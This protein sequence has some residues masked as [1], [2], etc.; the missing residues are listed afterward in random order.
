MKEMASAQRKRARGWAD[1]ARVDFRVCVF[2]RSVLSA[3]NQST[4]TVTRSLVS[5]RSP[6][7]WPMNTHQRTETRPRFVV[8]F[9]KLPSSREWKS[10]GALCAELLNCRHF[11]GSYLSTALSTHCS[12]LFFSVL[13]YTLGAS[14]GWCIIA[15]ISKGL[16]GLMVYTQALTSNQGSVWN[17]TF[18]SLNQLTGKPVA[19]CINTQSSDRVQSYTLPV[20]MFCYIACI[21]CLYLMF[22]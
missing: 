6:W 5:Q 10:Q 13:F 3:K 11:S 21:N 14:V 8:H 20:L 9:N 7:Q 17:A 4:F 15:V 22:R 16:R 12:N 19:F 2:V 1:A 18:L